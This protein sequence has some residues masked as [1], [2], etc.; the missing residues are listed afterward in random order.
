M[1]EY[2]SDSQ[3]S[4]DDEVRETERQRDIR[5]FNTKLASKETFERSR[6]VR[7]TELSAAIPVAQSLLTWR[8]PPFSWCTISEELAVRARRQGAF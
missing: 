5:N 8:K 4:L 6:K 2:F 7:T 3:H 1:H